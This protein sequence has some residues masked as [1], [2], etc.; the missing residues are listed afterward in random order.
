MK[1]VLR[2]LAV[3]AFV[4][5]SAGVSFAQTAEAVDYMASSNGWAIF[6]SAGLA[7]GLAGMGAGL[8]MG[9]AVGSGLEG[10]SRNPNAYNKIFTPMILGLA[11][12]ETIA[13]YALVVSLI[14][15][16]VI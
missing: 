12:L 15:L 13:I 16:F 7:I 9:R 10:I 5:V 11:F 14:L 2:I 1:N 8:A 3:V 4:V 6:I